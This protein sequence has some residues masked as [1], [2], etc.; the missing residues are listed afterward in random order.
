MPARPKKHAGSKDEAT[1]SVAGI[2]YR[3]LDVFRMTLPEYRRYES[4]SFLVANWDIVRALYLIHQ[5]PRAPRVID[6]A[7]FAGNYGFPFIEGGS[8]GEDIAEDS[9]FFSVN[10]KAVMSEQIDLA[11]P[12]LIA[13]IAVEGQERPSAV[14]IDG[15]HRLYKAARLG[16]PKLS[17]YVL[18]PDEERLC[19]R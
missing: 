5:Q 12:L 6:V 13:L 1:S 19:R 15:L 11:R 2:D 10:T 3:E 14:L 7:Q 17:A 18:T 4:Y 8:A 16:T 9:G